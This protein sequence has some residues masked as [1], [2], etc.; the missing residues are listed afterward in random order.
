MWIGDCRFTVIN[1]VVESFRDRLL[2]VAALES[3]RERV[4]VWIGQFGL[5]RQ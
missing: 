4:Y 2:E 5:S 1:D 3:E